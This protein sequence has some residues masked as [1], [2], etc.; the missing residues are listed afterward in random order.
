MGMVKRKMME[1]EEEA[2]AAF[3][4]FEVENPNPYTNGDDTM[5]AE[6][7]QDAFDAMKA[8]YDTQLDARDDRTLE[9]S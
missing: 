5:F 4:R 3:M 8:D 7:W 9:C 2:E 6:V 1:V